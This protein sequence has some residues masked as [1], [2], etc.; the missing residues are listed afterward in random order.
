MFNQY[1]AMG[2]L[3]I[4]QLKFIVVFFL[5]SCQTVFQPKAVQFKDYRITQSAPVDQKLLALLKPYGDSVNK[6]MNDV[7]A[8]A[9]IDL[10]KKQPEG[11]LG[12][13]L[14][15]A[16][17]SIAKQKY[18]TDVDASFINY[19]GIRLPSIAAGN[20]SRGKIFELAPFDNIIVLLKVNGKILTEFLNHLSL[21]N[22][23]PEAGASWKIKDKK[24][25]AI[26]INGK[27]IDDATIYTI[28]T[29][30]YVANG[31]DD[32]VMLRNIPQINNGTLFR[33]AVIEYFSAFAKEGKKITSKIENRI[34][35]A[36]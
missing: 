16:M 35:H 5:A 14:A 33:D 19:G 10:E 21:R 23:W 9:A 11:T 34:T 18:K 31:G 26:M 27:P 6:S 1:T 13:L 36:Q 4:F 25:A 15:D 3:F 2:K 7:I 30:D 8:V 32:C 20:I 28:A 17:L 29:L 24:A 12:N 22:G